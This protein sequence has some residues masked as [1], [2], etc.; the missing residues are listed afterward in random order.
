MATPVLIDLSNNDT[1]LVRSTQGRAGVPDGNVYF[2]TAGGTMEFISAADAP[3]VTYPVGHPGYTDGLAEANPLTDLLGLKLAAAYDFEN[4]ERKASYPADASG[5]SEDLRS[6]NRWT[7]GNFK[8]GGAYTFVNGRIPALPQDRAILRGSGWNEMTGT[9]VNQIQFGA[10]GLGSILSTSQPYRQAIQYGTV[11]DLSK[12]GNIDEA[13]QV[14]GDVSNGDFDDTAISAYLSIRTYGKNYDRIDTAGTLGISELAGYS[15][16]AALNESDHLTTGNYPLASALAN[17]SIALTS[18]T[19]DFTATEVVLNNAIAADNDWVSLGY[20]IGSSFVITGSTSAAN[21]TT[22]I[23]SSISTT[24]DANDTVVTT[25]A[26]SVIEVGTGTQ[27]LNNVQ[28]APWTSMSLEKLAV[29]QNETGFAG[30]GVGNFIWVLNNTLGGS[31]NQCVAYLDAIAQED[32]TVTIGQELLNGK[33]YDVWYEYTAAGKIR[34][35]V[36]TANFLT[37]GLFI[38]NLP[39]LDKTSVEF[40]DDA[41]QTLVYPVYTPVAVDLGAG[42]IA[43]LNAWFHAFEAALY[44]S[45]GAVTYQDAVLSDVKGAAEVADPFVSGTSVSFEH[46]YTTNGDQDVVFLCEGDGAVTQAKTAFTISNAAV[47]QTCIPATE[48]NV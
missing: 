5:P 21:N 30:A 45:A 25:V 22:Y 27:T 3:T 33:A 20:G 38:E 9:I 11:T 6:F 2:D 46:D 31:L 35:L 44:D 13:W 34:P 37:E 12:L 16:G 1:L 24:T 47:S 18:Q 4:R 42:A 26:P 28:V 7:N 36:G 8:F 41:Q 10:K 39:A 14:Y 43:D 19:I 40:V 23:I 15:T 48:T 32:S 17:D 29:A